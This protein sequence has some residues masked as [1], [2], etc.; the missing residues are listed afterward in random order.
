MSA[1]DYDY[2]YKF[3]LIGDSGV[4]KSNISSMFIRN[5]FNTESK[6]T[7]GVEFANSTI[8]VN[9]NKIR[10]QLWDTAGQERYR[11][12]TTAYYRNAVGIILIYDITSRK[13]FDNIVYWLREIKDHAPTNVTIYLI[14]NKCDLAHLRD[15][16]T[17]EGAEYATKN[18]LKFV[19]I[20]ALTGSNVQKMFN[21]SAK[22]VFEKLNVDEIPLVLT[23]TSVK[24]AVISQ[25]S[26]SCC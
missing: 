26:K 16:S 15:V 10:I 21:D 5:E 8:V 17:S 3:V 23:H 22:D 9:K 20:S 13:S 24:L 4:G 6:S 12:I 2:L 1:E 14:G 7:I 18:N 25:K 11:A 19:E